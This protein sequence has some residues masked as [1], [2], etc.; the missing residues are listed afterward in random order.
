MRL[1][2]DIILPHVDSDFFDKYFVNSEP[3]IPPF[4]RLAIYKEQK[5]KDCATIKK[6][7]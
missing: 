7:I 2:V 1:F 3:Y 4:I 5:H 6:K